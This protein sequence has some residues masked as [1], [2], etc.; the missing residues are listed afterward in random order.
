M[1]VN[2]GITVKI[3]TELLK[4]Y[5]Q[6]Y[7]TENIKDFEIDAD[8]IA[9]TVAIRILYE[10]QKIIKNDNYSDFEAIE[11]IVRVFEKYNISFGNRHNF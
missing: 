6:D 10:I 9:D 5:I 8:S 7:I 1:N 11:E 2:G 4:I 3:K